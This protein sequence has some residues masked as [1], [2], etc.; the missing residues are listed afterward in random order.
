M[1]H[2]MLGISY[3]GFFVVMSVDKRKRDR[4]QSLEEARQGFLK[5]TLHN[6]DFVPEAD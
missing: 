3:G 6:E 2:E 4:S 5:L 1:A